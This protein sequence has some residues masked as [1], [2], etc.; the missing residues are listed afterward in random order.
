MFNSILINHRGSDR[1]QIFLTFFPV[2]DLFT[3]LVYTSMCTT[4]KPR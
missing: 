2:I 3:V 1:L 4:E